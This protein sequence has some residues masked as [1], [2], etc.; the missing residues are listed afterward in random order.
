[1]DKGTTAIFDVLNG[2]FEGKLT[3]KK[4]DDF[5]I[6]ILFILF[7]IFIIIVISISKNKR[8]GGKGGN[9]GRHLDSR[10]LLEAIIL[11]NMGRGNYRS[12]SSGWGGS[13]SG[14]GWSG[15]SGGFGGGFGG[16]GFGGGGASGSW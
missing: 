14:G 7:V 2:E 8:G 3:S 13:S 11:S 9:R 16:G 10:D 6:G 12:S 1:L 15:G 5:P 4:S